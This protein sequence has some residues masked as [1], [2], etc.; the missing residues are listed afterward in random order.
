[1][2]EKKKII[3]KIIFGQI[4]LTILGLLI[5]GFISIPLYK[6]FSQSYRINKEMK[7]IETEIANDNKKS[8]NLKNVIEFLKSDQFVEEQARQNMGLKKPGEQVVIIKGMSDT[9]TNTTSA[10][11][12][13]SIKGLENLKPTKQDFYPSK[14][15]DYFFKSKNNT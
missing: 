2:D 7:E 5:L 14:W 1:M 12:L 10:D 8:E 11:S 15:R 6:N 4:F 13:F 9:E 3:S